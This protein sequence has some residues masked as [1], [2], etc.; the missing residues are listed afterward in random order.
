M[1]YQFSAALNRRGSQN[2][3]N[4]DKTRYKINGNEYSKGGF[5]ICVV[6]PFNRPLI[7]QV[8]LHF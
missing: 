6:F 2:D 4:Q 8:T 1:I 5:S 7:F 3:I